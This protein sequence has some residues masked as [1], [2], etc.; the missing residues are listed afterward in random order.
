MTLVRKCNTNVRIL[1]ASDV[2]FDTLHANVN[3]SDDSGK[4]QGFCVL[5]NN[6][7]SVARSR[8]VFFKSNLL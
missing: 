4:Y 1:M 8:K 3:V 2:D 6:I 7:L 5:S